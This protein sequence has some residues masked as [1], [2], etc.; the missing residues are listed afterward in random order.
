LYG[1]PHVIALEPLGQ[2]VKIAPKGA[3]KA[4]INV[5][6]TPGIMLRDSRDDN[7]ADGGICFAPKTGDGYTCRG[8]KSLELWAPEFEKQ[9]CRKGCRFFLT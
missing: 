2:F 8:L 4:E 1:E 5:V 3:A 7:V 9:W 6:D